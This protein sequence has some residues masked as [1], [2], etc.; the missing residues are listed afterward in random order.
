MSGHEKASRVE[1]EIRRLRGESQ[2]RGMR[3]EPLTGRPAHRRLRRHRRLSP[4]GKDAHFR[5]L[6]K[7]LAKRSR[8]GAH[9]PGE[10][11]EDGHDAF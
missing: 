10:P 3:V 4:G 11:T 8:G 5:R 7:P 1:I 9:D 2:R 6:P